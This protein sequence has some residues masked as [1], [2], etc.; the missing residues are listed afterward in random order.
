[1]ANASSRREILAASAALAGG[2]AAALL[3][4]CGGDDPQPE[5]PESVGTGQIATEAAVAATLLDLEDSAVVAYAAVAERLQ[6]GARAV[7]RAFEA[8]EREH[9]AALRSAMRSLGE[10]PGAPKP[11]AD[12]RATFPALRD[13][14]AALTYALDLE[15]TAVGAYADAL[16]KVVT[17]PMRATLAA[18][19]ATESEHAAVLLG[20]LGRR[21]VPAAFV[22]GPPPELDS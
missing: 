11:A 6:G 5:P 14:R 15:T 17:E 13:A 19:M 3:V 22:T 20:R 1:M 21:Q 4:S 18:I 8:H 10:E 7:A 12:Y 2:G 9:A 16:G